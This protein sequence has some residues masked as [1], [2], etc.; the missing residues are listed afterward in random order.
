[1]ISLPDYDNTNE[2]EFQHKLKGYEDEWSRWSN[3]AKILFSNLD[4]GNYELLIG[5]RLEM[6]LFLQRHT[7]LKSLTHGIFQV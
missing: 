5:L 1:M 4:P 6:I 2:I 3:D 7:R